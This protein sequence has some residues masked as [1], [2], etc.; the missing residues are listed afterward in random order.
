[1]DEIYELCDACTI[2]RDGRKIASHPTHRR[3]AA[4]RRIVSEM[5]GREIA[6][7][8]RLRGT[9]DSAMCA[10]T[11][12]GLDGHALREPA[13]FDVRR[14]EILGFFGLVGAGRSELMH[15]VYGAD[16]QEGRRRR[17]STASA[18]GRAAPRDA[19]RARH[20]AVPGRPQGRRHRRDGDRCRRT[21]ISRAAVITCARGLFLDRKKR[22]ATADRFI[23]LLKIKTPSRKQNIRFLSGGN[24]QKVDP[25]ALAGRARSESA[26]PRRADARH[27]RRREARNLQRDLSA[28]RARLRDR[29]DFVGAA[30]SA[31]HFA[32]AIV[33]MRAGPDRRR[34]GARGGE[35]TIGAEP[36]CR[37]AACPE[38]TAATG[39]LNRTN[40]NPWG[41]EANMEARENLAQQAAKS[42]ADA[43][44]PQTNDKRNGGSRSPNT[45]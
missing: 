12:E 39:S 44:I 27:R 28:G 35:R 37:A 33:V 36:R 16:P 9:R 15:L 7:H 45:A 40:G 31:G 3:R 8:L 11:V 30:G 41:T 24:Q 29:D 1:M 17:C 6:R 13:S 14:G 22:S 23:K 25:V 2:F 19:I 26:D 43:L 42:V 18:S 5:V 20:R 34:T 10:S 4:R 38:R 21:S 32:T